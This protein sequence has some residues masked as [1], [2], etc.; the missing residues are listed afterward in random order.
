MYINILLLLDFVL[1]KQL[2]DKIVDED[3]MEG[4]LAFRG[5]GAGGGKRFKGWGRRTRNEGREE[6]EL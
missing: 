5:E 1:V 4:V 3:E 2:E 6:V